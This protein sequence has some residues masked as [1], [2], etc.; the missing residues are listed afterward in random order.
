[1]LIIIASGGEKLRQAIKGLGREDLTAFPVPGTW[2]IQ[3][4]VIHL[5][6]SD[7]IGTDRMKRI[8]A[9]E[10]PTLVGYDQDKFVASLF[11]TS[12]TRQCGRNRLIAGYSPK[13]CASRARRGAGDAPERSRDARTATHGLRPALRA[14]PEVYCGKE[15]AAK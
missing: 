14:S 2:S 3:Q 5:M 11:T 1:M 9:E 6:D 4:I 15:E 7:L 10:N 12:S 13:F 8:I